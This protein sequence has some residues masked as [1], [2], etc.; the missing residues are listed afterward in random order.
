MHRKGESENISS[1]EFM[2]HHVIMED[3]DLIDKPFIL[4]TIK[5]S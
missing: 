3:N 4:Y 2:V 1:E 5:L